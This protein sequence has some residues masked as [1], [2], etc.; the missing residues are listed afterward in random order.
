VERRQKIAQLL[1]VVGAEEFDKTLI[2]IGERLAEPFTIL[3]GNHRAV[4]VF[5]GTRERKFSVHEIPAYIGVSTKMRQPQ[6]FWY[7]GE[8]GL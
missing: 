4:A 2:L 6:C 5:L 1:S 7:A 3:D 8:A